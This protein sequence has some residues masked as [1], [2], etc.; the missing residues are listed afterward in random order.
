[1]SPSGKADATG[2]KTRF[3]GEIG[4]FRWGVA[5]FSLVIGFVSE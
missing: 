4:F 2:E 5:F 3:Q 1:L